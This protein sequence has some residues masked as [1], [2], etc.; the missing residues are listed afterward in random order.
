MRVEPIDGRPT[1]ERVPP[2]GRSALD[3]LRR[4]Y[5]AIDDDQVQTKVFDVDGSRAAIRYR[6][7]LVEE[8]TRAL[9]GDGNL[10]ER[11]AQLL[12]E[13]CD[14][15]LIRGEDGT[16]QPL[17]DGDRVTFDLRPGETI[18]LHQALEEQ[19]ADVRRSV[20][21]LFQGADAALLK[22]AGEVDRWMD[23]LEDRAA[24]RFAGG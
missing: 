19:E 17:L 1:Q 21:R 6:R 11:N 4:V 20:L 13:A 10:W 7:L 9:N 23:S 22:H 18:A 5:N 8:R 14:E 16:L 3:E 15:I 24:E 12:I 2:V